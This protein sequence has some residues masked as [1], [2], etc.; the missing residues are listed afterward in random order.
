MK[1]YKALGALT[2][3]EFIVKNYN[4]LM[5]ISMSDL[6]GDM[7]HAHAKLFDPIYGVFPEDMNSMMSHMK[8]Y[9]D[10]YRTYKNKWKSWS[11]ERYSDGSAVECDGRHVKTLTYLITQRIMYYILENMHSIQTVFIKS[12]KRQ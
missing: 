6:L 8:L 10:R 5:G 2:P 9:D 1:H 3:K 11:K 4:Q 7:Y 12:L